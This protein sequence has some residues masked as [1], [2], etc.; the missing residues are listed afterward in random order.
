MANSFPGVEKSFALQAGR[1][2]RVF[3]EPGKINDGEAMQLA[4][5]L[6]KKIEQEL[7]VSRSDQSHCCAGDARGRIR[8][9][10]ILFIGDVVGKPGR[11][12]RV[13]QLAPKLRKQRGLDLIIANR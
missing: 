2:I 1:E 5:N 11:G 4:R 3:V 12:R 8:E 13:A 10:N 9:V 7:A 6:T